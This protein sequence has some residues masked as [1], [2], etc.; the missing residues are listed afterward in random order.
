MGKA[1]IM[2]HGRGP[3]PDRDALL[4]CWELFL[5]PA[6][7]AAAASADMVDYVALW[8]YQPPYQPPDQAGCVKSALASNPDTSAQAA[9]QALSVLLRDG[10]HLPLAP[11][12]LDWGD[13]QRLKDA[14]VEGLWRQYARDSGNQFAIDVVNFFMDKPQIRIG[15]KQALTA[16]IDAARN[17]GHDV[18]VLA[19]SFGTIVAYEAA[20]QYQN[21]EINTLVTLGSP[22]A[23]CYDIWGPAAPPPDG[24]GRPKVFPDR[25]LQR[26]INVYDPLDPVAT[27]ILVAA[28]P[29]LSPDYLDQGRQV[30][31]DTAIGNTYAKDDDL[32]S[33]HDWR[34]YLASV[35]VAQALQQFFS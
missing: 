32:G 28:I 4:A 6:V 5:E 19:H 22:L 23:W 12:G 14:A 35:P 21:Q 20:R 33:H 26:W 7:L 31:L 27:G 11:F 1:L 16:A 29:H 34:G 2:I 8:G 3:Q 13:L 9:L 17:N 25:G 30:V 24:Y 15:A 18:L 10:A